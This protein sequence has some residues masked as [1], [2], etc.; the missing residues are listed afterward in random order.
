MLAKYKKAGNV[1]LGAT[2]I[3]FLAAVLLHKD[4][5]TR[6]IFDAGGVP[7]FLMYIS[8]LGICATFWTYAKAK[9]HSGWLG[10]VLPFL[11]IIGLIILLKLKDRH[12]ESSKSTDKVQ[13]AA[14]WAVGIMIAIGF[15][16]L[17]YV[18]VEI[19]KGGV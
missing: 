13:P 17:A 16:A 2:A 19:R 9:G 14:R 11:S 18:F 6:N 1:A 10:I 8:T 5:A 3:C 12:P 7:V 4:S 15:A